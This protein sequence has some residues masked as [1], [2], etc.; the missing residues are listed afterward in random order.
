MTCAITS[1]M[2]LGL[3]VFFG[4]FFLEVNRWPKNQQQATVFDKPARFPEMYRE[5]LQSQDYKSADEYFD[6][7]SSSTHLP[8]ERGTRMH[9]ASQYS[10][11]LDKITYTLLEMVARK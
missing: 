1:V 8:M 6:Y 10:R 9:R 3:L 7:Q 4:F 2:I 11:N 5:P